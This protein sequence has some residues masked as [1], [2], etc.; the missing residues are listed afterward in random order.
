MSKTE[1][2]LDQINAEKNAAKDVLAKWLLHRYVAD[3]NK[4]QEGVSAANK[5]LDD[6]KDI[7]N[8]G[9]I[10]GLRALYNIQPSVPPGVQEAARLLDGDY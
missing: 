4:A 1:E 10:T 5:R 7:I 2:L 6:I 8:K 9:D 3:A